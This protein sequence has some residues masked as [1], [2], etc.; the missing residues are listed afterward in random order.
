MDWLINFFAS[1]NTRSI[2]E[3]IEKR[4]EAAKDPE[5]SVPPPTYGYEYYPERRVGRE[6]PTLTD[7]AVKFKGKEDYKK[8]KCERK[9]YEIIKESMFSFFF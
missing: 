1:F 7:M 9:V 3:E 2:F 5:K 4:K 6:P 8:Y